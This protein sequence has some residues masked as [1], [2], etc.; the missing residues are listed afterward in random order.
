MKKV[1]LIASSLAFFF[2]CSEEKQEATYSRC[3]QASA[4]DVV[5]TVADVEGNTYTV[6]KIGENEWFTSNLKTTKLNDGSDIAVVADNEQWANATEAACATYNNAEDAEMVYNYAAVKT[7]KLCPEG[8]TVPTENEWLQLAA[9]YASV[10]NAEGWDQVPTTIGWDSTNFSASA[11]GFREKNG[12]FYEE[13]NLGLWWT[14]TDHNEAN[15]MYVYM[16]NIGSEK[17]KY[18]GLTKSHIGRTKGLSVRCVRKYDASNT[19]A[20][21]AP[22][23]PVGETDGVSGATKTEVDTTLKELVETKIIEKV[24]ES[25]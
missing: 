17:A 10:E 7:E 6:V 18:V 20:K 14:S 5:N 25:K 8:W 1:I 24:E 13:G 16:R 15:A 2:A 23:C 21:P 22:T 11:A 4:D 12:N 9:T 19:Y 3:P